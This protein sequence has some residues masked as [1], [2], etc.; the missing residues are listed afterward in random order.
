MNKGQLARRDRQCPAS[1][2]V[3]TPVTARLAWLRLLSAALS[4]CRILAWPGAA[5]VDTTATFSGQET[6]WRKPCP[7][8]TCHRTRYRRVRVRGGTRR[9]AAGPREL[10]LGQE[11]V[12]LLRQLHL[13]ISSALVGETDWK[14]RPSS[15]RM[16]HPRA[17]PASCRLANPKQTGSDQRRKRSQP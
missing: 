2:A 12:L 14:R 7:R 15:H 11:L 17:R 16:C 4:D 13:L 6:R 8:A 10:V 1:T 5:A 9:P 3:R